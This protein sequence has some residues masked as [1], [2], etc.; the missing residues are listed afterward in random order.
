MGQ[1]SVTPNQVTVGQS[2]TWTATAH[3]GYEFDH[4][5]FSDG[6]TA[7]TAS[8]TKTNITQNLSGT[9]FFREK[10][11]QS[12]NFIGSIM[13]KEVTGRFRIVSSPDII[14]DGSEKVF[15]SGY[16]FINPNEPDRIDAQFEG[17][18]R[19]DGYVLSNA[20]YQ[21]GQTTGELNGQISITDS[22]LYRR[23]GTMDQLILSLNIMW[24]FQ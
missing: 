15:V 8:V 11:P 16:F 1:A 17:T 9:A 18:V 12:V 21:D 14:S 3:T 13:P 20:L 23:N 10:A 24:T 6:S 22:E 7:T 5:E 4:W 2:A 19:S